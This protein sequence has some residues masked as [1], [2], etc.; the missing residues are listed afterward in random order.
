LAHACHP[1]LWEAEIGRIA[2][3]GQSGAKKKFVKHHLTTKK[4]DVV[5]CVCHPSYCGKLK[6]GGLGSKVAWTK[7]ETLFPK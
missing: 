3:P 7:S 1:K 6:I 5:V 4:L 2:V